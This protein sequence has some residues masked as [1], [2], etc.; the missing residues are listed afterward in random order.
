ME[1]P[2]RSISED[3]FERAFRCRL[4]FL[5]NGPRDLV[6]FDVDDSVIV[7]D[8][9]GVGLQGP[10]DVSA[11]IGFTVCDQ[12]FPLAELFIHRERERTHRGDSGRKRT[13]TNVVMAK[14]IWRAMGKR[15]WASLNT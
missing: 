15:N 3:H 5:S 8:G 10:D 2:L 6:D 4:L 12:L 13:P 14:R 1:E 7:G 11:F 9:S